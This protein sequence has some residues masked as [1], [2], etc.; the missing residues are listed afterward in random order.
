MYTNKNVNLSAKPAKREFSS[1][2]QIFKPE[3]QIDYSVWIP[4]GEN[5]GFHTLRITFDGEKS[6]YD[7][8]KMAE[9]KNPMYR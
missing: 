5:A 9:S 1:S 3:R 2:D 6:F 4:T 8:M 7:L